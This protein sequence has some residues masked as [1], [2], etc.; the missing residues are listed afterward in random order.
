M[1]LYTHTSGLLALK[2]RVWVDGARLY[3]R[4]ALAVRL[5]SLFSYDKTVCVNRL[6]RTVTVWRRVLWVLGGARE[7][8]FDRI[9]SIEYAHSSLPTSFSFFYGAQDEVESFAVCLRLAGPRER[10]KLFSF[11]GEGAV[12]TGWKGV[13]FGNDDWVDLEGDQEASSRHFVRLLHRFTGA[14]VG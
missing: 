9:E 10:L 2:P 14:R 8:G 5:L 3:A 4:S 11:V 7:V 6:A 13:L 12:E 1:S